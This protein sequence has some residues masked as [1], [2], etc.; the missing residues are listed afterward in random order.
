VASSRVTR[1]RESSRFSLSRSNWICTGVSS[2]SRRAVSLPAADSI[3]AST[4]LLSQPLAITL[5]WTISECK[6]VSLRFP[7]LY[8]HCVGKVLILNKLTMLKKKASSQ[9]LVPV[10][11]VERRIFLIR[12]HKVVL[13]TD[14]A[15]LYQV[16]TGALNQAVR[17]NASAFRKTSCS[18]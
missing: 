3:C 11:I 18:N 17:R 2:G 12:G 4:D 6:G 9:D 7:G 8:R 15:A 1:V 13:D 14:L 5:L 16:P 10:E